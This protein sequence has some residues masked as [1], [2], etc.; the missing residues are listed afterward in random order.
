[1]FHL[2]GVEWAVAIVVAAIAAVVGYRLSENDRRTLGRT[3]WGLPSLLWALFWCLSWVVGLV[4]YL[5][6]HSS[7]V[8]RT[9]RGAAAG[10]QGVH[11][12]Q[13]GAAG[14]RA[15]TVAER[16]PAYPQPVNRQPS[17]A[18]TAQTG[19][20]VPA[21]P[22]EGAVTAGAPPGWAYSPPAWQ[23]DPSGRFHYRWWD[24][25]QWTSHVSTDGKHLLDTSPDQRIG[26]Y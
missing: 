11:G 9:Q 23:A 21:A 4:L 5:I 17:D 16:F 14:N 15:A 25:H 2:S 8:R 19:A 24:G 13:P 26:P 18:P 3:P 6:A 20:Q 12:Q 10:Y 7:E 22:H 1:V